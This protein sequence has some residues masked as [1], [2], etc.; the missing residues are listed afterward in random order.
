MNTLFNDIFAYTQMVQNWHRMAVKMKRNSLI[1]KV[2]NAVHED[3]QDN[4]FNRINTARFLL[5]YC[6]L[7]RIWENPA[8]ISKKASG[9]INV[10]HCLQKY[11]VEYF[12][13][14]INPPLVKPFRLKYLA[15]GQGVVATPF[16]K[17]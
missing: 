1:Y 8:S 7:N 15:R 11:Y 9:N 16:F 5:N 2:F 12:E 13:R 14:K 6:N 4:H 3:Y 10:K 17:S